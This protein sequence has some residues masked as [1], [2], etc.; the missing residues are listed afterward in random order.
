MIKL[1]DLI[2]SSPTINIK[3]LKEPN[4]IKPEEGFQKKS[5]KKSIEK[6]MS[7]YY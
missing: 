6:T 1:K 4:F 7:I 5:L 3:G 2:E